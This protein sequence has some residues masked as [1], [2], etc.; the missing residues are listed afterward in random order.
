MRRTEAPPLASSET[1]QKQFAI[2]ARLLMVCS[3]S[4]PVKTPQHTHAALLWYVLTNWDHMN[5]LGPTYHFAFGLKGR[6]RTSNDVLRDKWDIIKF[7]YKRKK[8]HESVSSICFCVHIIFYKKCLIEMYV[9]CTL[10]CSLCLRVSKVLL[11][12]KKNNFSNFYLV[13]FCS[14]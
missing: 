6:S 2:L 13:W 10:R 5:H 11:S 8:K 4:P 1:S 3:M 7:M 12:I 9:F 14:H